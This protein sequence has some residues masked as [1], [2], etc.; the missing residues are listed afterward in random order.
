VSRLIR[1][2]GRCGFVGRHVVQY[3][4]NYGLTERI[5]L[6]DDS[7]TRR[8]PGLSASTYEGCQAEIADSMERPLQRDTYPRSTQANLR[9]YVRG[10]RVWRETFLSL[11]MCWDSAPIA[12]LA[13]VLLCVS[14]RNEERLV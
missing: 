12:K 5:W 6:A 1:I 8:H 4:L 3:I 10:M 14:G 13:G 7:F 9:K 11:F 2:T